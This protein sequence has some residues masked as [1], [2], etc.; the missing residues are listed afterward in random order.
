MELNEEAHKVVTSISSDAPSIV[1]QRK[2][3]MTKMAISTTTTSTMSSDQSV[4]VTSS[5]TDEDDIENGFAVK[6]METLTPQLPHLKAK[7]PVEIGFENIGYTVRVG[8][9]GKIL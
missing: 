6:P 9:R 1:G 7:D 8:F 2:F 4:I 5:A 3:E